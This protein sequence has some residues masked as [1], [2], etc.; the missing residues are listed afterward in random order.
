MAKL[1]VTEFTGTGGIGNAPVDH[2]AVPAL[3]TQVVTFTTSTP[4]TNA[5]SPACGLV[6][7]SADAACHITFA[8]APVATVDMLRLE[9]NRVYY[10][11]PRGPGL[12]VAAIAAA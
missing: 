11:T 1:W 12:K 10:F 5:F 6:A 7:I 9:A 8:A 3:G 4:T 2:P